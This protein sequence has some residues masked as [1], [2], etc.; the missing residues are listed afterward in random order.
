M[1]R[2]FHIIDTISIFFSR[3]RRNNIKKQNR[4]VKLIYSLKYNKIFIDIRNTCEYF[5]ELITMFFLLFD[6]NFF[7]VILL[8]K[9]VNKKWKIKK[10]VK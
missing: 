5:Y 3:T 9:G 4:C 7:Y 1:L 8:L 2:D 10:I 6:F